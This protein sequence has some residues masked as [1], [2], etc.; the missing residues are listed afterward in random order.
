[1][2]VDFMETFG[3]VV[4]GLSPQAFLRVV[5]VKFDQRL[6]Y[7]LYLRVVS[8]AG[9]LLFFW[10]VWQFPTYEQERL[11]LLICGL[12]ALSALLTTSVAV[13]K[14]G[15]TYSVGPALS[16]AVIPAWGVGAAILL[17]TGF[18]CCLWLIKPKDQT[19]WKK[20]GEQL[21]FNNGLHAIAFFIGGCVLKLTRDL[22]GADSL[23]GQTIPWLLATLVYDEVNLWLLIGIV[24]LQQG[25]T[26]KPLTMWWQDRWASQISVLVVAVGG[27]LLAYAIANY[28][29]TGVLAFSLPI[30]LSAYAFRLYVRQMEAHMNNLESIVASRTA[31]LAEL[32]RQKDA[33]LAVLTHDMMTPLTSIQLCAEELVDDPTAALE[34]PHLTAVLLKSQQTLLN[35]VRDILDIEKLLEGHAL[36]TQKRLCDLA[37]RLTH[38]ID[39]VQIDADGRGLT[40]AYTLERQ[41]LLIYADPQQLE[42][43]LLN[44]ISNAVKYTP[45]GGEVH[46]TVR[47]EG[48]QV[49]IEVRDTGYG[50]PAE[51]VDHIFERFR[52]VS[53][54]AQKAPGN[55][56]GL[57]ITKALVEEHG[58]KIFV[59]SEVGRGSLFR[60][61]LPMGTPQAEEAVLLN[62]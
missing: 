56:L 8:L 41:P 19:T 23:W 11:F 25:P 45:A 44:L 17:S 1:V 60:V 40:L 31:D 51:E 52:R 49:W 43:I 37:H 46:A 47:T 54:L 55:G 50:I 12:A 16:M 62:D 22:L 36:V 27:G 61:R 33:Y 59:E 15:I 32:N 5:K 35:M 6:L 2:L 53:Q 38:V 18:N 13:E 48:E 57:A 9:L 28:Q 24:R 26:I 30:I 3:D 20:S 14:T 21:A 34:N 4:S 58:G 29:E 39:I 42:R 7:H 10:G